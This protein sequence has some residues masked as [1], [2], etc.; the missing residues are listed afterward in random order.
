MPR[1]R[2]QPLQATAPAAETPAEKAPAAKTTTFEDFLPHIKA[3]EEVTIEGEK[4]VYFVYKDNRLVKYSEN[5]GHMDSY[6]LHGF[7]ER[8]GW[9]LRGGKKNA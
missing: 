7:Q 8:T 2:K 6:P 3:G 5:G 4:G 9:A 1:T